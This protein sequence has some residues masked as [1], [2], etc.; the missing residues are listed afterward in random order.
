MNKDFVNRMLVWYNAARRDLPWRH[1]SDP[2]RIWLS[3]IMLQQTRVETVKAYYERFL[4]HFPDIRTLAHGDEEEVLKCW[5]GLGYYSRARN[6]QK[7]AR[8]IEE[9]FGGEFPDSLDGIRS[10]PGIGPYSAGAVAS[11]AFGIPEPAVDGNVLRVWSRLTASLE[12]VLD[13]SVR[14]RTEESIRELLADCLPGTAFY[15]GNAAGDFNQSLI[16]LGAVICTPG[17]NP[18]CDSCP[19]KEDCGAYAGHLT[20]QLPVRKKKGGKRCEDLT[21]LLIRSGTRYAIR[22][23]ENRGLLAGLYE[24]PHIS[25][26]AGAKEIK[27]MLSEKRLPVYGLTRLSDASHTF[28]HIIWHMTGYL[29]ETCRDAPD[30]G[31]WIFRE[32]EAIEALYPVPSAFSA[33]SRIMKGSV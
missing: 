18:S 16:E 28:S 2:Y 30:E 14:R 17:V 25:G 33:Y 21:V 3:E 27:E 23:R 4:V 10:L 22:R 7:A 20:D 11:I 29:I 9:D 24:F 13:P 8:K 19:V 15:K 6:M 1:T 32:P 12:N 31:G 26:H 5:E